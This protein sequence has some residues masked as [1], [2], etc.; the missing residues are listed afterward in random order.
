MKRL[1]AS[2]VF[3]FLILAVSGCYTIPHHLAD[4]NECEQII[5]Y[6]EVPL[7]QPPQIYLPPTPDPGPPRPMIRG[8]VEERNNNKSGNQVRDPLRGHGE[9]GNTER[10]TQGRK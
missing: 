2:L 8:P 3:L 5:I 7:P 10:N 1:I 4:D 9:R 6:Y